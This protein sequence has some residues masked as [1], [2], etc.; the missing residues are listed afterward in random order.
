M[1]SKPLI[2]ILIPAYNAEPWISDA[3]NSALRQTW[4]RKEI[5]I[6]D[7]GSTDHT[8]SIASQFSKAGV[9]VVSQ[10]NCGASAARNHA[11]SLC[12]GD[13]IQWLDADD[14]LAPDK[15]A[16]QIEFA[17]AAGD[18]WLLLSSEWGRFRYRIKSAKFSRTELWQDLSPLDWLLRKMSL[19]IWMQPGCWLVSR[20]LTEA[21]GPW[22]ERLSFDDD[23]EYF[24]RVLLKCRNV[25]FVH[26]AK[27]FHR[28]R[29][30]SLSSAD[31]S[32]KQLDSAWLSL[33]LHIETLLRMEKSGRTHKAAITF[34]QTWFNNFDPY[35]PDIL[36]QMQRLAQSLGGEIRHVHLGQPLRCKFSWMKRVFGH[37]FACWIQKRWSQV[38]DSVIQSLHV[39]WEKAL[40]QLGY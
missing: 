20:E 2:S 36:G 11:Y 38:K 17:E 23:G 9:T 27:T 3:I 4:R 24:C 15:I 7:D 33:Q 35:R 13:Y 30:G 6:V 28:T 25:P 14:V 40:F 37:R 39:F 19:N 31:S 26:G 21:A 29:P 16:R 18:P 5:I 1:N 32:D 8:L 10:K 22:D 34:L 12:H